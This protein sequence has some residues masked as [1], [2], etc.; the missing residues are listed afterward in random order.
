M[1]TYKQKIKY[2]NLQGDFSKG[3]TWE[4]RSMAYWNSN[5]YLPKDFVEKNPDI[6]ELDKI[7]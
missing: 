3:T 1:K 5:V 2:H 6:F 4:E 7:E